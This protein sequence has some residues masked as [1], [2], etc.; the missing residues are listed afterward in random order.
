MKILQALFALVALLF[1]SVNVCRAEEFPKPGPEHAWLQQ[2]VG[3]W[4]AETEA[5]MEPGKP[6]MRMK[7]TESVRP[8]GAFWTITE[9]KST[10]MD[11]PFTGNMTLGYDADKKKY[12]GTWVDSMT[13]HLWQY[14]GTMDAAGKTLTLESEGTCPMRPGKLTKFR[15]VM[16][17]KDKDHKTFTSSMQGDDGQWVTMMT[18]HAQRKK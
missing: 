14:E 7:G 1:V 10:M 18:S 17:L 8:L 13:G 4:E 12:V 2:L 5:Y 11:M 15:E 9:V 3:E 6:P 16:E